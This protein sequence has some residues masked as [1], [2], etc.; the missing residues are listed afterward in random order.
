MQDS[1]GVKMCWKKNLDKYLDASL[2]KSLKL[3]KE[4]QAKETFIQQLIDDKCKQYGEKRLSDLTPKEFISLMQFHQYIYELKRIV[5][6][7]T[8]HPPES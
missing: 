4:K 3:L 2:Q 8:L 1:G 5:G 7:D 6:L